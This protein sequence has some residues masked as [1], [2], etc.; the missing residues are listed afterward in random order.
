MDQE[1]VA[2]HTEYRK[3]LDQHAENHELLQANHQDELSAACNDIN[4]RCDAIIEDLQNEKNILI[5]NAKLLNHQLSDVHDRNASV[6]LGH[7]DG[8]NALSH[9]FNELRDMLLRK[10]TENEDLKNKLEQ[11]RIQHN[12]TI[13]KYTNSIRDSASN[14][15]DNVKENNELRQKQSELEDV[16]KKMEGAHKV[17]QNKL[18]TSNQNTIQYER[19]V[20]KTIQELTVDKAQGEQNIDTLIHNVSDQKD[21]LALL[22]STIDKN[23]EIYNAQSNKSQSEYTA[24]LN[25]YIAKNKKNT[26]IIKTRDEKISGLNTELIEINNRHRNNVRQIEATHNT[27]NDT[28]MLELTKLDNLHVKKFNALKDEHARLQEE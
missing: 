24:K 11:C 8:M 15:S 28:A 21:K 23:T 12:T 25:Q 6:L 10:V 19:D 18:E 27:D 4:G 13:T 3:L 1:L 7:N 22:Q 2:L 14:T 5:D 17:L 9:S 16:L 26:T 20:E